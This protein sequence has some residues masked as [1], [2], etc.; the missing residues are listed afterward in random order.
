MVTNTSNWPG[1]QL[2]TKDGRLVKNNIQ[3]VIFTRRKTYKLL[4]TIILLKIQ[5]GHGSNNDINI[6][7]I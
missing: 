5:K 2:A 6:G 4:K 1:L 7:E 3:D